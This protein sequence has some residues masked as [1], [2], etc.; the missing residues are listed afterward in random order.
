MT[1]ILPPNPES[2]HIEPERP[3]DAHAISA[4]T[5]AAFAPMPFSD[6]DE[7]RVIDDLRQAG[8]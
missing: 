3:G 4:M 1:T 8:A 7:A 5:T 6:G 2:L